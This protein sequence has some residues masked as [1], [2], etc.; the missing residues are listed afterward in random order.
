MSIENDP[1]EATFCSQEY[2]NHSRPGGYWHPKEVEE[3]W[4]NRSFYEMW[5]YEEAH[6]VLRSLHKERVREEAHRVLKE[7]TTKSFDEKWSRRV[8]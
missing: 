2:W 1:R 7:L 5:V 3:R 8:F 4:I 6:K